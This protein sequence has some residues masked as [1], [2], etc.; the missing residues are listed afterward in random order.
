MDQVPSATLLLFG[1]PRDRS[2]TLGCYR[3]AADQPGTKTG[4]GLQYPALRVNAGTDVQYVE[5]KWCDPT[6]ANLVART[7]LLVQYHNIEAGIT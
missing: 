2:S 3:P 1:H 6:G 5:Y 4:D 7:D